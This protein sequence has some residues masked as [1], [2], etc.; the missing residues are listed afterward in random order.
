MSIS[1]SFLMQCPQSAKFVFR[2]CSKSHITI[3]P[4]GENLSFCS[5]LIPE[6]Q[7]PGE[8]MGDIIQPIKAIDTY[9]TVAPRLQN[10]LQQVWQPAEA[11][12]SANSA[13][14]FG[15]DCV[16]FSQAAQQSL[17]ASENAALTSTGSSAAMTSESTLVANGT[18]PS[19]EIAGAG[20][21]ETTL[22]TGAAAT[23]TALTTGAVATETAVATGAVATEAAVTT[24][25]V[26]TEAAATAGVVAGETALAAGAVAAAP[27]VLGVAAVAAVGYGL[28]EYFSG[29]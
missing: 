19:V 12:V 28:Y 7:L 24:G 20:A 15:Q 2:L 29:S 22:A 14:V 21:T 6:S 3:A 23:E 1:L 8:K 4:N 25:V 9:N 17:A 16:Q 27:V 18:L 5:A 11:N 26:A 13:S 10:F